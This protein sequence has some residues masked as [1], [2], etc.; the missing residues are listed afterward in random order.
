MNNDQEEILLDLL[1]KRALEGLTDA[2]QVQLAKLEAG[3]PTDES[4][5]LVVSA[6]TLSQ[7]DIEEM[8]ATLRDKLFLDAD[9]LFEDKEPVRHT[10]Q[11]ADNP[12]GFG[13]DLFGWM[14]WAAA[15]L[16][17]AAFVSY[18]VFVP[19]TVAPPIAKNA[20][21]TPI[22]PVDPL[23]AMQLLQDTNAVNAK[24]SW[25][26]GNV[27]E[28][29]GKVTGTIVWSDERQEGYMVFRGLPQNNAS[30]ETYQLWIFDE[31]QDAKT[32]IDG[33]TFNVSANG[34][35]VIPIDAKLMVK[36]PAMFAVTVEKP[37][38]VVVSE[39]EKIVAL[40]KVNKQA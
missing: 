34:E 13:F 38:G 4:F 39:R 26:D 22:V 7:L 16:A 19:R 17:I 32:P 18:V 35:T 29:A 25:G 31:T 36:N 14:G 1:T 33:G 24:A 6:L 20:T 21:P 23:R 27:T 3:R 12:K 30:K 5:D 2:E 15:A 9:E 10:P 40:A 37:G 28:L 8:P 11:L